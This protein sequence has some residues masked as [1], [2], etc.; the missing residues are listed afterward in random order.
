MAL[1]K[2]TTT[3]KSTKTKK[4]TTTVAVKKKTRAAQ[5]K[6]KAALQKRATP[7]AKKKTARKTTDAV[8]GILGPYGFSEVLR[9]A[10][11]KVLK[12]KQAEDIIVADAHGRS[13]LTD[14]VIIASGRSSRQLAAMASALSETFEQCG[15][16]RVKTEG[17]SQGDWVLVDAGDVIV[18]MFRPEVRKY[19][20]IEDIWNKTRGG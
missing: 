11:V 10:A 18:H 15:V 17:V 4:K 1:T 2:K 5:P 13:A 7:P 19:Y 12:D 14:Y 6:T 8:A 9:D 3:T 16:R 20:A